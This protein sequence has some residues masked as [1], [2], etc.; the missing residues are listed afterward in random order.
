MKFLFLV[1]LFLMPP[2]FAREIKLLS[3][4]HSNPQTQ[5]EY[6]AKAKACHFLPGELKIEARNQADNSERELN[7][8]EDVYFGAT[9]ITVTESE[10]IYRF[11]SLKNVSVL[12]RLD[13]NCKLTRL[14]QIDGEERPFESLKVSYHHRLGFPTLDAVEF[15]EREG[16]SVLKVEDYDAKGYFPSMNLNWVGR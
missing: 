11:D 7:I 12:N 1:F 6:W 4:N 14:V 9:V 5:V 10:L 2:L 15:F 13:E 3:F 16:E 8:L